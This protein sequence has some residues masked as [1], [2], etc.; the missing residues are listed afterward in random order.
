MCGLGWRLVSSLAEAGFHRSVSSIL[1]YFSPVLP[2]KGRTSP[3]TTAVNKQ[4]RAL[5]NA[6]Q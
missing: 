2:N 6:V 4:Y 5:R 3:Y 1:F